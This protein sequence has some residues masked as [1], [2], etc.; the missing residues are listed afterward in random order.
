MRIFLQ[1]RGF[2]INNGSPTEEE[3]EEKSSNASS[4][5]GPSL[6]WPT[7]MG[8]GLLEPRVR[9]GGLWPRCLIIWLLVSLMT[10]MSASQATG[11][12]SVARYVLAAAGASTKVIFAGG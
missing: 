5:F 12:L 10:T 4:T 6:G 7:T 2:A 8:S 9:P 11:S 3:E 1:S